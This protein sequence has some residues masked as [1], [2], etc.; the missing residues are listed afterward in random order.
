MKSM[1]EI[2]NAKRLMIIREILFTLTDESHELSLKEIIDQ[3]Q[4]HFGSEYHVSKNTVRSTIN[5]LKD[6][7]FPI[8]EQI[9]NSETV[10][11]SHQYRKFE[12][13]ELRMLIDAVSSARFISTIETEKLVNKIKALTSN[14]LAK[15]LQHQISVDPAIKA[16]NQEV[17]Y[18]IDKIH[19]SLSERKCIA[20]QYGNYNVK[21]EFILRHSGKLYVVI[22][23]AL[24]WN[25]DYYY[26]VAKND[27]EAEIKHYRVDRMKN[28]SVTEDLFLPSD[29]IISDHMKQ[30]FNMYPGNVE[31]V[32]IQFHKPLVNVVI[33]RFGKDV[34]IR[35]IDD[36]TFSIK[37][38]AAISEGLIRWLLTWGSDAKVISPQKLVEKMKEEALKMTQLYS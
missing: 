35:E 7:G 21:K 4:L 36:R 18:H 38:K 5:E 12:V 28:V 6:C 26:L 34:I 9:G 17:R 24:V 37:I 31:Y 22:P 15:K 14:Y 29:F 20:F 1:R 27:K 3:L 19:T 30:T 23:L 16:Q 13:H 33:D 8:E 10:Y 25:N 32:E 11:Y 2:S